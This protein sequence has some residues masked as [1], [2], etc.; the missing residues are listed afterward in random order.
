MPLS[1]MEEALLIAA[2]AGFSGLALWDLSIAC[3]LSFAQRANLSC[4]EVR[5]PHEAFLHPTIEASTHSTPR[6]PR[7][8]SGRSTHR[9]SARKFSPSIVSAGES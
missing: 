6:L 3:T 9:T 5:R 7:P 8:G 4:H 2:V 1:E